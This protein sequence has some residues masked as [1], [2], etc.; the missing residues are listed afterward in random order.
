M[1]HLKPLYDTYIKKQRV[2]DRQGQLYVAKVSG[3]AAEI[4]HAGRT[5]LLVISWTKCQVIQPICSS[6]AHIVQQLGIC[7]I[8]HTQ[9]PI[10]SKNK[11]EKLTEVHS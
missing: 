4:L 9:F 10:K 2:V 3:T 8:F 7:D 1:K 11:K 5:D 6:I